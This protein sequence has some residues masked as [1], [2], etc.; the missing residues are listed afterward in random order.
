MIGYEQTAYMVNE[1]DTLI[2]CANVMSGIPSSDVVV[3]VDVFPGSASELS[4]KLVYE[5]IQQRSSVS[6]V[7]IRMDILY[8]LHYIG[9]CIGEDT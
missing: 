2:V 3:N 6:I 4:G 1:G 8:G 9:I 7:L 5:C